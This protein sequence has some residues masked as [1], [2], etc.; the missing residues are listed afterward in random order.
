MSLES[1]RNKR[2]FRESN[3]PPGN[4]NSPQE[5]HLR[6]VVHKHQASHL[7]YDLRLEL[8]GVLK[9]WAVPKEITLDPSQKR[10]A[11]MV[12][13]HPFEY[14]DFEGII[15]EGNYGAGTVM[16]WDEGWYEVPGID[17][18]KISVQSEM[19]RMLTKGHV[20]ISLH[21]QKLRGS[22]HLI[23]LH[24]TEKQN[25]W[26]LF[27]K[28]DEYSSAVSIPDHR[29]VRSTR[30]MDE[31]RSGISETVLNDQSGHIEAEKNSSNDLNISF[32]I[33]PMLASMVEKPFDRKDWIFEIKW[34]GYRAIAE[35][36]D[37][38]SRLYSRN[39][40]RL[41]ENYPQVIKDLST[42]SFN[43]VLDGELVV[44]NNLGKADFEALQNFSRTQK[45][46]IRYYVF[47]LLYYNG[48]DLRN[49]SLLIRKNL[50][51]SVLPS[52]PTVFYNEH[53]EEFGNAFFNV[54]K[55]NS[56]EG[57]MAKDGNSPY[58]EGKRT[59][60]WL[61]VKTYRE[62]N[63]VIAGFTEPK[64]GRTGFG[65]LLLGCYHENRLRFAGSVG[66]GFTDNELQEI[67]K[68]LKPLITNNTPFDRIPIPATRVT[69]I[70]PKI[71]C[72]VT[73]SEWTADGLLRQPVFM[74]F[75]DD[76]DPLS[77]QR[78]EIEPAVKHHF[79]LSDLSAK[80]TT[81]MIGDKTLR[82]TNINK[83]FWPDDMITKGALMDYYQQI[84][85]VILPHLRDR[86]QSLNRFPDGIEGPHFFQKDFKDSPEWMETFSSES[87]SLDKAIRYLLC[88]DEASLIYII[89]LGAI[90][91]NVW[92]SRITHPD[93]PDYMV[94]DLDPLLCPFNYVIRTAVSVHWVMDEVRLPHYVKTSGATGL[95]IY[96]P[97]KSG[98]S[99]AQARQFS[100]I[101]C[102]I[103]H[104]LLP[105]ITSLERSPQKR[106]GKVYLDFLQN[107]SGKTMAAP[108]CVRPQPHA[109]VSTP[110]LWEEL[111]NGITPE[112]FTINTILPRID[113][114][115]DLWKSLFE[116]DIAI[117]DFLPRLQ[118]LYTRL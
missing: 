75:R 37:H 28:E 32:P 70:T 73:F 41:N 76:I 29:S 43:A 38:C 84:A 16:I 55:E 80:D 18:G 31:I 46:A 111:K 100:E 25:N 44:V 69:W 19:D 107:S 67:F 87:Q 8:Y 94:V 22:F 40:K 42:L 45:G 103:V 86:P 72:Q 110:L 109:T 60:Y 112:Q 113:H 98:H 53:V 93:E 81:I 5:S 47:D 92:S 63:F 78:E 61:K 77:V 71:V 7:H 13:D 23:R 65:A 59:R 101:I 4:V 83:I 108:Y 52:L 105:D 74:R 17:D 26:L 27:K 102:I 97:L 115:G 116:N 91:L 62:Q 21:G 36:Y 88:Q 50:L 89:N 10:L 57:M 85:S 58:I 95:H 35:I 66:S 79:H 30:T 68:R 64:G 14:R 99:F 114:Y 1:Y 51:K 34:D 20:T 9:S 39:G 6:F 90:E 106:Y 117:K 49:D 11:I 118:T 82:L 33:Q 96:V 2:D 48:K 3:E 24:S 12:E 56:I 54:V 15:P 104:N